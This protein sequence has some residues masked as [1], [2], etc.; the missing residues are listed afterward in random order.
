V[1]NIMNRN[2]LRKIE[3]EVLELNHSPRG[4]KAEVFIR[5]ALKLGR[6]RVNR[7]KEPTYERNADP[8]FRFPLTIPNH[9]GDIKIGTARKIIDALLNDVDEWKLWLDQNDSAGTDADEGDHGF[10]D[11]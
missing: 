1:G 9:P 6:V 2:R 10:S 11:Q 4:K 3:R 7:G 5:I 8:V